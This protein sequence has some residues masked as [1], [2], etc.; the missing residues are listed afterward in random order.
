M[1]YIVKFVVIAVNILISIK[2]GIKSKNCV[3]ILLKSSMYNLIEMGKRSH[4]YICAS[5]WHS[6]SSAALNSPFNINRIE[7][8]NRVV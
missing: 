3:I 7:G 4:L 1:T 6:K 2:N 5:S 8:T